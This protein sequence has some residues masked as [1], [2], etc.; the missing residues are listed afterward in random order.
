MQILRDKMATMQYELME[1]YGTGSRDEFPY[2][3][4]ADNYWQNFIDG[5]MAEAEFYDYDIELHT[6]YRP[7]GI[8]NTKEAFAFREKIIPN[9]N[10]AFLFRSTMK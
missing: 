5:L 6:K 1:N 4:E 8:T 7:K 9:R 3:E 2:G 10:N